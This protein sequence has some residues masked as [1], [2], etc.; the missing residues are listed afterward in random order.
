VELALNP[1][2]EHQSSAQSPLI[3]I[4]GPTGSGKTALSLALGFKLDGEIVNCD[5]VA[6]YREF[7]VGTAKPSLAERAQIPH[8]LFDYVDPNEDVTAGEYARQAREVLAEIRARDRLPIVVG[9][10]GLYLRGL[11]EGLF[12]GPQRSEELRERLRDRAQA[13]GS[14]Y[15]HKI[16]SRM[17]RAAATKIHP[18]DAPKLIRAI[19]VCL[20]SRQKMSELW[21]QGRDPLQGFRVLRIGLDPERALLYDRINQRAER[22]FKSGLVDETERL[23]HKYGGS[24]R[25]MNS[26]AYKQAA[27]FLRGELSREQALAAAKQAHRNYAKRQMTWF[28]KEPGVT[29]LNGFGDDPSVQN[30]ALQIVERFIDGT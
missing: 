25:P 11:L 19:E 21:Q 16:L 4:L 5:S 27:Q 10:T 14:G 20:A 26:L 3:A 13:R 30:Q 1:K 9:G 28:R 24:A 29:W 22:M 7:D 8:H 23:L 6:M 18:N 12:P 2:P 15:L 17:D